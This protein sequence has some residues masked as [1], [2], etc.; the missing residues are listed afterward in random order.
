M[1]GGIDSIPLGHRAFLRGALVDRSSRADR[2]IL[3]AYFS[4]PGENYYYGGRIDLEGGN[5][6]VLAGMLSARIRCDVFRI[7]P[8][9]P[10]PDDYEKTVAR[11]VREQE[12]DA[13]PAISD[14]LA[15][16]DSW[17]RRTGLS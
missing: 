15:S 9:D 12:A 3:L 14:P 2:R 4:R 11:N 13:R 7:R 17:L 6:E 16:I 10:Y 5:T 1:A 8:V